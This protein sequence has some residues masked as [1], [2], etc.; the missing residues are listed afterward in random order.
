MNFQTS[1]LICSIAFRQ[2]RSMCVCARQYGG[3]G[4]ASCQHVVCSPKC[5]GSFRA[6][7][8][9]GPRAAVASNPVP[10]RSSL[11][12]VTIQSSRVLCAGSRRQSRCSTCASQKLHETETR[13][14][15]NNGSAGL[16]LKS[17]LILCK[18]A[19]FQCT[20]TCR[21][22]WSGSAPDVISYT[23]L[24]S[25]FARAGPH[26]GQRYIDSIHW[27]W[28]VVHVRADENT[29]K[30]EALICRALWE[31][32]GLHDRWSRPCWKMVQKA[33]WYWWLVASSCCARAGRCRRKV[34][35]TPSH[36]QT[37]EVNQV[38]LRIDV[39]RQVLQRCSL[40]WFHDPKL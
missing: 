39:T 15:A 30:T 35:Q 31:A 20:D 18:R 29:V 16:G 28:G 32:M 24:I 5:H 12:H 19:G 34:W 1:F 8:Q 13:F 38:K 14:S 10:Y 7:W 23:S 17:C 11:S 25:S 40:L 36:S 27:F 3:C 33:S 2:H 22:V 9:Q 37:W 6:L 4:M 21:M 26:R